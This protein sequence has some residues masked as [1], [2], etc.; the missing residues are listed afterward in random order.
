MRLPDG[1]TLMHGAAP[2]DAAK[3]HQYYLRTR[4]LKGRKKGAKVDPAAHEK[5]L[6]S[7]PMG[8]AGANTKEI[9]DL[10]KSL[11]GKT[12]AELLAVSNT[13]RK[14]DPTRAD[15]IVALLKNRQGIRALEKNRSTG[16]NTHVKGGEAVS[17]ILARQKAQGDAKAQKQ[18]H[19][20][21]AQEVS[22]ARDELSK[23]QDQLKARLTDVRATTPKGKAPQ[24]DDDAEAL[25]AKITEAKGKLA[26]AVEKQKALTQKNG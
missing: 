9:G 7:L 14:T 2:Y 8:K 22:D 6:K 1:S 21:A 15:T 16:L 19:Q 20:A 10:V 13:F 11:A 4:K 17:K 12:D 23:L 18:K 26:T 25:K 5:F 24:K 3:A